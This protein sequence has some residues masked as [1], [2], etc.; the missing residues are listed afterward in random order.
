MFVVAD[1]KPRGGSILKADNRIYEVYSNV[2]PRAMTLTR[3]S[4]NL[5]LDRAY[6]QAWNFLGVQGRLFEAPAGTLVYLPEGDGLRAAWRIGF[7]VSA[8]IRFS[9]GKEAR[10]PTTPSPSTALVR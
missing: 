6:D 8:A 4:K 2:Q 9:S 1:L 3:N 5:G 10:A 7:P